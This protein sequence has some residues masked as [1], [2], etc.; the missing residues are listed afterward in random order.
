MVVFVL[1]CNGFGL[2]CVW[3]GLLALGVAAVGVGAVRFL[4]L[5][6]VGWCV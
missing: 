2:V 4:A 3:F 5:G 6:R 1:G